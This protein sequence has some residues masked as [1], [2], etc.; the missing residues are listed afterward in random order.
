[1]AQVTRRDPAPSKWAY[2]WERMW[3]TPRFRRNLRRLTVVLPLLVA[4]LYLSQNDGARA[5]LQ[6]T[7]DEARVALEERPEFLLKLVGIEGA[8]EALREDI[9]AALP[10]DFPVSSFDVDLPTLR[11]NVEAIDAVKRAKL[12]ILRDNTLQVDVVRRIPVVVWRHG[13]TLDLRDLSGHRVAEINARSNAPDLPLIVGLG[14]EAHIPEALDLVAHAA[15]LGEGFLGLVRVG[16]RRWD[17]I[18]RSGQAIL[19]PEDNPALALERVL[20]LDA[21]QSLLARDV[22]V[23][24]MRL[25]DRPTVRL[26]EDALRA[27]RL[28]AFRE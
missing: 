2:R 19:L 18:L 12:T 23:V 10:L 26:G 5:H 13:D 27:L 3:M 24:D 1:M 4:L 20:F 7:W 21:A 17:V 14:A 22:A 8:D 15:S 16:A 28:S 9:R 25:P 11:E 6:S